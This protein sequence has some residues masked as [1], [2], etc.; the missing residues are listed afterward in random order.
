M[1]GKLR[2]SKGRK[3]ELNRL[4]AVSL[5]KLKVGKMH[6]DG[7]GLYLDVQRSGSRSWIL[8]TMVRQKRRDIGLVSLSTR[9]L[10]E[11]REEAAKLRARAKK[12]EHILEKRRMAR[13]RVPTFEEAAQKVHKEVAPTLLNE[14]NKENWLRSLDLHV[15]S[16]FGKK[17]VDAVDSADI[18]RAVMP[19]WTKKPDM[20]RKTLARIRRVMDW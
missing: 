20:A 15:F 19:I 7:N 17:A 14:A 2:R 11:A 10:A 18:L 6:N 16:V 5:Q 1:M 4:S 3:R 9:S 8:R 13:R 12:G